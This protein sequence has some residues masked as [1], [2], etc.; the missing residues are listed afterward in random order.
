MDKTKIA[1]KI[2]SGVKQ[3]KD[4]P[5]D[6]RKYFGK[7]ELPN[8]KMAEISAIPGTEFGGTRLKVTGPADKFGVPESTYTDFKSL[9]SA[10]AYQKLI[11]DHGVTGNI[12]KLD[13]TGVNSLV[14]KTEEKSMLGKVGDVLSAPQRYAAKKIADQL[15]VRG[16]ADSSEE[17]FQNLVEAGAKK[18]GVPEDSMLG[19]AGKAAAVAGL[20]TFGDPLNA[21]GGKMAGKVAKIADEA[22][23]AKKLKSILDMLKPAAKVAEQ[24]PKEIKYADK[25]FE[26]L[27]LKNIDSMRSLAK[28]LTK[29]GGRLLNPAE[30]A[31]ATETLTT[32]NNTKPFN[33]AKA[34][35]KAGA[36]RLNIPASKFA[37]T[38]P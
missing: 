11:D 25:A 15:G 36:K 5:K 30:V 29:P 34:Q 8:G 9:D 28:A 21:I 17:T 3:A 7:F 14:G 27:P 4:V 31:K 16:N 1:K 22:S 12:K 24:A 19:A 23:K 10:Q 35:V 20:E 32:L 33:V 13:K 26:K 2:L 37:K 38:V 18:L 6:L